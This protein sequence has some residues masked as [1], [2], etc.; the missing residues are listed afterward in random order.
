MLAETLDYLLWIAAVRKICSFQI[1]SD[2]CWNIMTA[3]MKFCM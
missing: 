2:N 1:D 3:Y